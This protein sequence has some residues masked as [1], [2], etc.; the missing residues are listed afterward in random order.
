MSKT[1]IITLITLIILSSCIYLPQ[2]DKVK[3]THIKGRV[4]FTDKYQPNASM[5]IPAA[6]AG[7]DGKIE[8]QYRIKG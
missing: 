6:Y 2:A 5:C 8:G 1:N 4:E 7:Y 3:V